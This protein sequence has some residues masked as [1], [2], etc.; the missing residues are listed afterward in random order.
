MVV[1]GNISVDRT[2]KS[3]SNG[4]NG[5]TAS[6]RVARVPLRNTYDIVYSLSTD[7]NNNYSYHGE[8]SVLGPS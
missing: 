5:N 8:L 3:C 6:D 4:A 1:D 7:V 2:V